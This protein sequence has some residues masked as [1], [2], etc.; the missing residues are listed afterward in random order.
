LFLEADQIIK[1][2]KKRVEIPYGVLRLC[3]PIIEDG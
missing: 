3:L 2:Q 1:F